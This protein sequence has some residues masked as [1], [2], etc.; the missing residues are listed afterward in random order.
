MEEGA[1]ERHNA[2]ISMKSSWFAKKRRKEQ[3]PQNK[4]R[5]SLSLAKQRRLKK[6]QSGVPK[7]KPQHKADDRE[8][9]TVIFIPH[10]ARSSLRIAL[11]QADDEVTK[12]TNMGRTK[13]IEAA[14]LK[15]SSQLVQK[16]IWYSLNG[17]CGRQKCYVCKSSSGKGISCR[18][19]GVCYEITCKKCDEENRRTIYIG[20]TSRSSFERMSEHMWLFLHKKEGDVDKNQSNSVLWQHSK[21]AHEGRLKTTD[22]KIKV[23]SSHVSPLSRQVTEAVRISREFPT[24]ILNSKNEFSANNIAELEVRYGNKVAGVKRKRR[25]DE[26]VPETAT[27]TTFLS[28]SRPHWKKPG[29]CGSQDH[30]HI[31]PQFHQP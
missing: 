6:R 21:S 11:Q 9:E 12:A 19:E 2:R 30:G 26:D 13:Y 16:N 17:G 8:I 28:S 24:N 15:L 4:P 5:P 14:G 27:P 1:L 20:E 10:T 7:H 22:W 18:R 23:V 3:P 25:E 29:R 31:R